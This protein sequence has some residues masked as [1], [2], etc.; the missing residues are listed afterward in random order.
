MHVIPVSRQLRSAYSAYR[1]VG[2]GQDRV[3]IT[4]RDPVRYLPYVRCTLV[5]GEDGKLLI[6]A[7]NLN[8]DTTIYVV[9]PVN[10]PRTSTRLKS[11]AAQRD[12]RVGSR[13]QP[14]TRHISFFP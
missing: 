8:S 4:L 9:L 5:R 2:T 6:Q 14:H 12:T 10:E 3:P 1:M 7:L 13:L 11:H